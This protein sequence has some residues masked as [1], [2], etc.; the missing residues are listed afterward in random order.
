MFTRSARCWPAAHAL[1]LSCLR[2]GGTANVYGFQRLL[3]SNP[4]QVAAH[5]RDH[6]DD[7][8]FR[9]LPWER[10]LAASASKKSWVQTSEEDHATSPLP[11][12]HVPTF[13]LRAP[14]VSDHW[15]VAAASWQTSCKA[16]VRVES[17]TKAMLML[18]DRLLD[19]NLAWLLL[20]SNSCF[21]LLS[22]NLIL[23]VHTRQ[24][25]IKNII[26]SALTYV[27]QAAA[28]PWLSCAYLHLQLR[29]PVAS[30]ELWLCLPETALLHL[31]PTLTETID[32]QTQCI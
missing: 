15:F 32:K 9:A 25:D 6:A 11:I 20:A 5:H 31:K 26:K 13:C 23:P 4:C 21:R 19:S 12:S 2:K 30:E 22:S 10:G 29:W 3:V 8:D 17:E 28:P 7:H 24:N 16:H 14:Y 18:L 27:W 1:D